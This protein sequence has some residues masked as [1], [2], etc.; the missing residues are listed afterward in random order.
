VSITLD[1]VRHIA[2]LARL[3]VT[4]AEAT[5][6]AGELTSILAHMDVLSAADTDGVAD[7]SGAGAHAMPLRADDGP[8]IAMERAVDAFAPRV[9]D[10]FLLVPRLASHETS[11]EE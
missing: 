9:E 10:G 3:G 6:L 5:A 2:A 7:T 1:D 11:A 8:P 4:D